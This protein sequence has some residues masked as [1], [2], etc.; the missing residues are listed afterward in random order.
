MMP[1]LSVY[2]S[3]Q[4]AR[5]PMLQPHG[6]AL[7]WAVA[8]CIVQTGVIHIASQPR[9]LVFEDF[10]PLHLTAYKLVRREPLIH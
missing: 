3:M 1:M 6:S 8:A 10:L 5:F 9:T 2:V 4:D 7:Y